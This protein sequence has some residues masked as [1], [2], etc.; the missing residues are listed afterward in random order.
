MR[1][2]LWLCGLNMMCCRIA[3]TPVTTS[4]G[5]R[6][7]VCCKNTVVAVWFEYGVLSRCRDNL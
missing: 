5:Q 3:D 6:R 4:G 7:A 2:L 1:A